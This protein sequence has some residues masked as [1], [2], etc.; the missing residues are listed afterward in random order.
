M[1]STEQLPKM[2]YRFVGRSGLQIS[3]I[4]LG[5][6]V[7]YGGHV[8]DQLA[9]DCMKAAYDAGMHQ[10]QVSSSM[11]WQCLGI[12]FFDCA[13]GYA[14]GKSEIVMGEAIKKY[15]FKRNDIVISTKINWGGAYGDNPV[16]NGGLY[17]FH[18]WQAILLTTQV[19]LANIWLRER[20]P[21]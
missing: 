9:F 12:N 5:G 19:S 15:G 18:L 13:E 17:T 3:V 16:N 7:T 6:W 1:G 10:Y 2:Q 8:G 14:G 21:L 11:Y 4:S 20:K